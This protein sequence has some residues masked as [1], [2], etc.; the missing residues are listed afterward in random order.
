[1]GVKEL[2]RKKTN[3]IMFAVP[4]DKRKQEHKDQESFAKG[5]NEVG[6]ADWRQFMAESLGKPRVR[7]SIVVE[8]C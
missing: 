6:N 8:T 2:S 5:A 1:M 4:H 7:G 3:L